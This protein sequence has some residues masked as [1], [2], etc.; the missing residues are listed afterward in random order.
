M[1]KSWT[2]LILVAGALLAD[3]AYAKQP[4]PRVSMQA[5]RAKALA[6]APHG[7]I[8]S[9]ELET[10]N[11]RLIYSFDIEMPGRNGIQEVQISA[12]DG[13]VV[14]VEHETAD[15]ERLEARAEAKNRKRR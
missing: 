9:A 14:S 3:G 2:M 4:R 10:E 5:A 13:R 6:H 11:G 12:I 7:R 15:L 8:R 1:T